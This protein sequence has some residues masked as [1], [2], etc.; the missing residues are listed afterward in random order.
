M[1]SFYRKELFVT[2]KPKGWFI[3]FY[4]SNNS[5]ETWNRQFCICTENL[6]HT[7]KSLL[8]PG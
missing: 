7:S 8:K 2:L 6:H 3:P 1:S 4:I 5:R